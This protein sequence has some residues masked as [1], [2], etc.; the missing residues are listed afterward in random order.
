MHLLL[1]SSFKF[2][3]GVYFIRGSF[4]NVNRETLVL[5]Q[6]SNTPSYRIGFFVDEEIVT[7]DLDESLNDNS[8][9][10][11]NYAAPGADRL[12]D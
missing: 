3:N 5:D 7:A 12:R 11:N 10:F 9:G 6:Y 2:E 4:V 1:V 8:Q